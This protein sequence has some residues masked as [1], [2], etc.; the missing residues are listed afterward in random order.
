MI[1]ILPYNLEPIDQWGTVALPQNMVGQPRKPDPMAMDWNKMPPMMQG[2][3]GPLADKIANAADQPWQQHQMQT[4]GR[5]PMGTG[6]YITGH[7]KYPGNP[8]ITGGSGMSNTNQQQSSNTNQG[9]V[10]K[11]VKTPPE[12]PVMQSPDANVIDRRLLRR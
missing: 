11:P 5:I 2:I 1:P 9:N 12:A 7:P 4:M 8:A 3:Y 6:R 10:T